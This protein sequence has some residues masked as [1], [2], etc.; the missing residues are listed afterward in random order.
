MTRVPGPSAVGA[1]TGLLLGLLALGPALRRG[2]LLT[3]DMVFVP[4]PP[5]NPS[6]LGTGDLVPRAVPNDV[7]VVLLSRV[8]PGDLVQKVLLLMFFVIGAWGIGRLMP[9]RTAALVAAAVYVWNPYVL[10]RLVL[11]HWAFLLGLAALPWVV[12]AGIA[13][14]GGGRRGI[15][16]LCLV[17]LLAGLAGSTALIL[18]TLT[19]VAVLWS[20]GQ[21]PGRAAATCWLLT[22]VVGSAASWLVPALSGPGTTPGDPQGVAAFAARADSPFGVLGSVASLGGV[23]NPAVWPPERA[24]VVVALGWL[25]FVLAA[26]VIGGRHLLTSWPGPGP[27]LVLVGAIGVCLALWG[28]APVAADS[29]RWLVTEV[30]GA[31][32]LRDGQ[33][34]VALAVLPVALCAGLLAEASR[35]VLAHAAP[36]LALVPLVALPSLAWAANGRLVPVDY[37][38][39][40]GQARAAVERAGGDTVVLPFRAYRRFGWNGDRIVLDPLPRYLPGRVTVNDALPLSTVT[41]AGEDPQAAR[42][43]AA[44]TGGRDLP[45]AL[46]RE[47][48]STVVLLTDQPDVGR[49]EDRVAALPVLYAGPGIE[50]RAVPGARPS[51]DPSGV[52]WGLAVSASALLVAAAATSLPAAGAPAKV[53]RTSQSGPPDGEPP[54]R[55]SRG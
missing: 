22:A 20:P 21:A 9:T 23:W 15:G 39:E 18:V 16:W 27:G 42:L 45:A 19:A 46:R 53:A 50:V 33:K 37:P 29:L 55:K 48:L 11:G 34:F 4:R 43:R 32:L 40:W 25:L 5:L 31:G 24:N 1:G 44:L 8:M 54:P 13:A 7:V 36:A 47:G 28:A 41:V 17:V 35:P 51:A 6:A 12:V 52:P 3:Y 49:S 26:V 2:Y 38:D 10:E 30:P 14:R